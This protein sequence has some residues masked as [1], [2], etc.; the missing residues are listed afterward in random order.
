MAFRR[1]I[2]LMALFA[3]L[4]AQEPP[5]GIGVARTMHLLASSRPDYR[6][7]VK[8]LFYGQSITKQHW[9]KLVAASLRQRYPLADLQ[10]VNR[11]IG[12]F[13]TQYL[14]RTV[15]HDVCNYYPDLVLFHVY[16][17]QN[18]YEGI[19]RLIR[20]RTTAE[21]ALQTDHVSG[22]PE[23]RERQDKHSYEWLKSLAQK[24]GLEWV[25]IRRP[26]YEYLQRFG[27]QPQALLTDGVHLNDQG[28]WLLA[29]L[30]KRQLVYQPD[31]PVP[32]TVRDYVVGRDV[33]WQ[34]GRLS[35]EFDGNRVEL[36]TSTADRQ[37]YG[38]ARIQ[39]DGRPP[40]GFPELY[41]F[42]RP[43]DGAGPDWPLFIHIGSEAPLA[44]EDWFLTVTAVNPAHSEIR[45]TLRGSKT[46]SDGE[47]V[48]SQRF[49]S[50][51]RRV[52]IEPADW[53][54]ERAYQ[55][56]QVPLPVGYE[57]RFRVLGLFADVYEPPR[58]D[59][60][61]REYAT[62]VASGLANTRHRLELVAETVESPPVFAIRVYNPPLKPSPT[63]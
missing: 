22:N 10:I 55:L 5:P 36:L 39:I 25:E 4:P 50:R 31:L 6:R 2:C 1:A 42:E 3:L 56:R 32:D 12:G 63:R 29:E 47:G 19:I 57:A 60:R 26:W 37:P 21:I 24:Y 54:F 17:S 7:P 11:A 38:R 30:V 27:L 49:V 8:V 61:T 51:S 43:S 23:A 9:W 18:E 59:D 13:S 40:S 20:S 34:D 52:T 16:G 46:G 35:L 15:E 45:F 28:N 41:A 53:H 44:V 48:S 14:K 33:H 58:V 62:V